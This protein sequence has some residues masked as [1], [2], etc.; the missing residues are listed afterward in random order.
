MWY[1]LLLVEKQIECVYVVVMLHNSM[2]RGDVSF[3]FVCSCDTKQYIALLQTLMPRFTSPKGG[4]DVSS[5]HLYVANCGP[6]VGVSHET[7]ASVFGMYGEVEGVYAADESGTRVIV[8]YHDKSS[9]Q[10]AMKELN[11]HPCPSLGGRTLHI[12]YSV[13]SLGK[14]LSVFCSS[15]ICFY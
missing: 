1:S 2:I 9:S 14:V 12:Q 5:P 15:A 11:R 3:V 7:I 10:A 6:A 13:Q 4:D 8:S